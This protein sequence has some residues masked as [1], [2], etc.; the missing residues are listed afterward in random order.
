MVAVLTLDKE[1]FVV[2]IAFR[3]ENINSPSSKSL[4]GF[5]VGQKVSILK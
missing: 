2:H 1:A 4:N 3:G 5:V